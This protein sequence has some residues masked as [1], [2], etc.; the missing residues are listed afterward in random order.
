MNRKFSTYFGLALATVLVALLTALPE[1]AVA[2]ELAGDAFPPAPEPG[3][4]DYP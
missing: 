1:L 4:G 2:A 3:R